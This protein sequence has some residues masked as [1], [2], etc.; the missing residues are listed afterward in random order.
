MNPTDVRRLPRTGHALTVL[1]L[2]TAPLGSLYA[3]V[4]ESAARAALDGAWSAGI[5]Y[6][7]TAPFYGHGLAEHRVGA[8]LRTR[9]RAGWTLSTKVGRLLKPAVDGRPAVAAARGADWVQPLPFEPVFDY[10]ASG[11]RRSLEDSLQRLGVARVDIALV[12]DIGR[13]THGQRHAHHW[14]QLTDGGGLRELEALRRERLVGAI[15][16]GVNEWQIV[17]D[18]LQHADLDCVLLAGRYTLLEQGALSFLQTCRQR[19]VGVI[20]GGPFNSGVLASGA[21]AGAKFDYLDAP[22]DILARVGR[23]EDTCR[24]FGVPL[25]AAALQF[26][27]AHPAVVSVVAG[28][29]DAGELQQIVD[30]LRIDIPA[31]LWTALRERGLVEP[32]APLP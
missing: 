24:E 1:G 9:P 20:V 8:A 14:Q 5:R 22:A 19:E 2:G 25:P 28:P 11:I 32:A 26:P 13:Y 18:T 21:R 27:L 17:S 4:D 31:G 16:L 3:A 23:L 10:S 7:D 12:H 15:G 30:W 6:F 29:R